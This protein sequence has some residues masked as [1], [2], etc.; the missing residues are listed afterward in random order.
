MNT[1]DRMP[2]PSDRDIREAYHR[3]RS[4][5]TA[6]VDARR[7]LDRIKEPSV[8]SRRVM[9]PA[10]GAAAIA[11]VAIG[12][13][14][15]LQPFGGT[16]ETA[17]STTTVPGATTTTLPATTTTVPGTTTTTTSSG[18]GWE[19][20]RYRVVGVASGDVLNVRQRPGASHPI[21]GTLPPDGFVRLSSWP[22]MV[23]GTLWYGVMLDD[24]TQGFVNGA[25]LAPP[26]AWATGFDALACD[27]RDESY[28]IGPGRGPAPEGTS[29]AAYV[30]DVLS[31]RE[32]DCERYVIVLGGTASN[33]EV[34]T[35]GTVHHP[36]AEWPAG[37]GWSVA[38]SIVAVELPGVT[39]ATPWAQTIEADGSFALATRDDPSSGGAGP[40]TMRF[41]FDS[42]RRASFRFLANPARIAIDVKQSPTG[43]GLDVA[44]RRGG[45][46]VVLP[47]QADLNGPGVRTPITVSGWARP[48]E[49]SGVAVLRTVGTT[50]GSG[51]PV[52]AT[53]TGTDFA[54]TVTDTS[55]PYMTTDWTEAWGA[56]RFTIEDLAPGTYELFVGELS[57]EDGAEQGVYQVFT[58][59]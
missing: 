1:D 15:V 2:D 33:A 3:Q 35:E 18:L 24:G 51:T 58:V 31:S 17:G 43:T 57:M 54:G 32:G 30:L 22:S 52:E 56:F 55:Y 49:A 45:T 41:F 13:V 5:I 12:V 6:H 29:N 34:L 39:A 10:L 50:P 8:M 38:G 25:F 4:R 14:L 27:D 11:I 9:R 16:G 40:I 47:I 59:G 23:D 37:V 28:T 20:A 19:D 53:F 36:A 46:A 48:F 42:N 26:V 21:V 44:A 7:G